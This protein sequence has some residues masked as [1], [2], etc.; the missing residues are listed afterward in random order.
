[1]SKLYLMD[2]DTLYPLHLR[3]ICVRLQAFRF[4]RRQRSSLASYEPFFLS[5]LRCYMVT[6]THCR[7][8]FDYVCVACWLEIAVGS[9][10]QV[11]A[12]LSHT[13]TSFP[14][15][16]QL[17]L[18]QIPGIAC[19]HIQEDLLYWRRWKHTSH[20][21]AVTRWASPSLL[22]DVFTP[23]TLSLV[24]LESPLATQLQSSQAFPWTRN[25]Y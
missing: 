14:V 15:S 5:L 25:T 13:C 4:M 24:R 22:Y 1:M 6:S 8:F 7:S 16:H 19:D 9:F 2:F 11:R 20:A 17:L 12:S 18:L 23:F 21:A 3:E 10:G